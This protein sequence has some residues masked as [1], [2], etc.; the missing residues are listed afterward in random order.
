VSA[1]HALSPYFG[2]LDFSYLP[3]NVAAGRSP[4]LSDRLSILKERCGLQ[5]YEKLLKLNKLDLELVD[6]VTEEAHRRFELI[7]D[8]ER[9]M[10]DFKSR[11]NKRAKA[12]VPG[13]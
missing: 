6:F 9:R 7:P 10:M 8:R 5:F 4:A 3:Q 12:I 1:E 2:A 11:C 13:R